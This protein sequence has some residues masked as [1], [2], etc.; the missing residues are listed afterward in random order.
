MPE[1]ASNESSTA[2]GWNL[3]KIPAPIW[4]F[5]KEPPETLAAAICVVGGIA[6]LS[7][8][9]WVSWTFL[10]SML[11]LKLIAFDKSNYKEQ[12]E[13]ARHLVTAS[14]AILGGAVATGL[15]VWRTWLNQRQTK[16]A[17]EQR[18]L[19]EQSHYTTL[20]T[21]A[22]E[23]LGSMIEEK[24]KN[25]STDAEGKQIGQEAIRMVPNL[26]VRLGAIYSLERIAH[27]S[28]RDHWPIIETLCAYVRQESKAPEL[29]EPRVDVQAAIYAIGKRREDWK[30]RE[31]QDQALDL[32][33]SSLRGVDMTGLDF[34][35]SLFHEANLSNSQLVD[36]NLNGSH[37][38]ETDLSNSNLMRCKLNNSVFRNSNFSKT[39]LDLCEF[40]NSFLY[41]CAFDG[42]TFYEADLL[43]SDVEGSSFGGCDLSAAKNMTQ[44]QINSMSYSMP[45][46]IPEGMNMKEEWLRH[47]KF[48]EGQAKSLEDIFNP[49]TS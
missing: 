5:M 43:E 46:R 21:K 23:Q 12:A 27:D 1:S 14:G 4:R 7:L 3:F 31:P 16:T 45:S 24:S 22:V 13:A 26:P 37:F 33:K 17:E 48:L 44:N 35:R 47:A 49:L 28:F 34:D 2:K 29:P 30:R 32:R 41:F 9:L 8:A 20:F 19:A 18:H 15:V 42:S 40:K 10:Q 36:A 38:F 6:I 39:G 11:L 25:I